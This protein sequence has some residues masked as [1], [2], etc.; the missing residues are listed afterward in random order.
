MPKLSPTMAEGT[1]VKWYKKE[2]DPVNPGDILCDVET[3]K[4][5]VSM[6]TEEEGILAKIIVGENVRDIKIGRLIAM[7]VEEGDDWQNVKVPDDIDGATTTPTTE[8]VTAV[9]NLETPKP[10][11]TGIHQDG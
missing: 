9:D 2:G 5:T 6:D 3:D 7:I 4:A 10:G 11:I 8:T 1:I